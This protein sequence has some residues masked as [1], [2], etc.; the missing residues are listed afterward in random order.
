MSDKIGVL[1]EIAGTTIGT[2]TAY[3]AP[4]GKGAKVKL[5]FRFTGG[6]NSTIDIFVNGV[7]VASSGAMTSGH[8]WFSNATDGAIAAAPGATA[9]TGVA[10]ASTCS[11]SGATYMLSAG[12]MIQYAVGAAALGAASMQ[13]VGVET[14][15][16]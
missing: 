12:D 1:G 3:I 11:P 14:D 8:F 15:A 5:F 4:A 10:V 2:H 13:V 16:Q 6:T 7:L 9:P